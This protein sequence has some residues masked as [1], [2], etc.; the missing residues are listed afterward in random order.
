MLYVMYGHLI[1][2]ITNGDKRLTNLMNV[3]ASPCFHCCG[4]LSYWKQQTFCAVLYISVTS[5]TVNR[6]LLFRKH[7]DYIIFIRLCEMY[8]HLKT[9]VIGLSRSDSIQL[10]HD[11]IDSIRF[12]I[13]SFRP[14]RLKPI[15]Q[16]AI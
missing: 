15:T 2:I 13:H 14:I 7:M 16:S 4:N 12:T 11:P 1:Y 3:I 9:Y 5:D 10:G 8:T 6:K